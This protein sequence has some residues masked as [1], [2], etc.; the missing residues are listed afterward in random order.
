MLD[1]KIT[2]RVIF[3]ES[4]DKDSKQS[5]ALSYK[6]GWRSVEGDLQRL[7]AAMLRWKDLE[8]FNSSRYT[9]KATFS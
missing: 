9:Y 2:W 7:L 1:S 6:Y 4:R 8:G 3:Q 5:H